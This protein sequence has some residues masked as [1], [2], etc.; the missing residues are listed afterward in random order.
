MLKKRLRAEEKYGL[1]HEQ[2]AQ[3]EKYLRAHKTAGA[4][5][6]TEASP[7]YEMYLL[8][9][10]FDDIAQRYPQFPIGRII[11]TAALSGWARD[12]ER[13]ASSV[14][15]RIRAR[16][17]RSTVEQ[18]EF[19]TDMISV[20]TKESA[21]EVQKYLQNPK[22]APPPE[23]RIK[24]LKDYQQVV[25]MLARVAESI[26]TVATSQEEQ[27]QLAKPKRQKQL[28]EGESESIL[29]AELAGEDDE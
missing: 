7:L 27:P 1:T 4:M 18:V 23:L 8:G 21:E 9:Y 24:S 2:I 25:E 3:A 28:K 19:L 22:G 14:Y 12:R 20:S 26:K 10:S 13:L 17:V 11:L 29:L 5:N 16:V 15:E 6:Q